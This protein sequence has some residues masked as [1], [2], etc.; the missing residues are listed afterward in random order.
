MKVSTPFKAYIIALLCAIIFAIV[1]ARAQHDPH[2]DKITYLPG[3]TEP[4]RFNQFAG[5]LLVNET[6]N[7]NL[8]YWFVES[9]NDPAND[10]VSVFVVV[11]CVSHVIHAKFCCI[12]LLSSLKSFQIR[13]ET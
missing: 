12:P 1:T 3:Y 11:L 6:N 8:F 5:Y 7:R 4:I 9:Q 10:P 2:S 13:H